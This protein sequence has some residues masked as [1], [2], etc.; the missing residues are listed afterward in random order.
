MSK[1]KITKKDR[2]IWRQNA[3][4]GTKKW[5]RMPTRVRRTKMKRRTH[6]WGFEGRSPH[7]RKRTYKNKK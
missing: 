3:L 1:R 2:K 4:E 5:G 7:T 6:G